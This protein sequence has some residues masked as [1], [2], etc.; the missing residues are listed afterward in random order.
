[1]RARAIKPGFF[2]NEELVRLPVETRLLFIGLWCL[3]D[4]KGRM[5]DRPGRIKMEIYPAE[6][7]DVS[8]M[9]DQLWH[10]SFIERY[11]IKGNRYI[12]IVNF[13][14]HQYP[15]IKER[16]STIPAPDKHQ[17]KTILAPPDSLTP[18]VLTPDSL[19][20][21]TTSCSEPEKTPAHE[22]PKIHPWLIGLDLYTKDQRLLEGIWKV[23]KAWMSA[24]PGVDIG[25]EI[26]KAHSWEMANPSKRKIKRIAFL[27]NWLSR[28]QDKPKTGDQHGTHVSPSISP[29]AASFIR[30]REIRRT[31]DLRKAS[32]L[33][34]GTILDGFRDKPVDPLKR[35]GS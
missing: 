13:E 10:H 2:K 21:V 25:A 5:E 32:E 11:E 23:D 1:M 15:H 7:H 12:Q 22:P 30:S 26:K 4:R 6:S 9:L 19:T 27:N 35:P 3:A 16:E 24:F 28:Q 34:G 17:I 18:V 33:P 14:K 29:I 8:T 31:S 20:P